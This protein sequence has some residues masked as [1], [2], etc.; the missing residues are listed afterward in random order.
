[1]YDV[2]PKSSMDSPKYDN[3]FSESD[4]A[5]RDQIQTTNLVVVANNNPGLLLTQAEL[6]N[7]DLVH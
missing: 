1:M 5:S 3:F 2:T 7:G 6:P 4:I